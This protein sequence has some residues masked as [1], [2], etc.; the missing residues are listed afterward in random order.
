[1]EVR[2]QISSFVEEINRNNSDNLKLYTESLKESIGD[3][4]SIFEKKLTAI[5]S[6]LDSVRHGQSLINEKMTK[7]N[8]NKK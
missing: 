2:D 7:S 3:Y 8:K 1:M 4:N 5:Q 6:Q